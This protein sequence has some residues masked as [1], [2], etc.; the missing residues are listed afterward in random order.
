MSYSVNGSGHGVDNEKA[1]AAFRAFVEAL[2]EATDLD[3]RVEGWADPTLF[4]GSITGGH[5]EGTFSLT[6]DE[7][8]KSPQEA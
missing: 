3:K 6:A 1:K 5:A 7:A 8:R 4:Q 2:D